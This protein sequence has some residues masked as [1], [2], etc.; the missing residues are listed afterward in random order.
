M[1]VESVVSSTLA[2][3]R[4]SLALAAA[5]GLE[6]TKEA[7]LSIVD[8]NSAMTGSEMPCSAIAGAIGGSTKGVASGLTK[9][10]LTFR[11]GAESLVY[12]GGG[13]KPIGKGES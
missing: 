1:R 5:S 2:A 7:K 13:S 9:G 3:S 8:A 12:P 6:L 10:Y 4:T 11:L